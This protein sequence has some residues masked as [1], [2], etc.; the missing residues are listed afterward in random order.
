VNDER[1]IEDTLTSAVLKE[2][3]LIITLRVIIGRRG[4]ALYPTRPRPTVPY[5]PQADPVPSTVMS[6]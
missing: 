4:Y 2:A 6:E 1:H 3:W 5:A